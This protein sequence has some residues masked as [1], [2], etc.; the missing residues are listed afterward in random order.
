MTTGEA[1]GGRHGTDITTTTTTIGIT[2]IGVK[3]HTTSRTQ[4]ARLTFTPGVTGTTTAITIMDPN[5]DI[6][7]T[8]GHNEAPAAVYRR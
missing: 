8:R 5:I 4:S 2:I 6:D 1:I 3:C 7:P